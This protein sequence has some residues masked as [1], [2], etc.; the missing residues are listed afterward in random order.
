MFKYHQLQ[1]KQTNQIKTKYIALGLAIFFLAAC[2]SSPKEKDIYAVTY[3]PPEKI[4]L[5]AASSQERYAIHIELAQKYITLKQFTSANKLLDDILK[6]TSED[7]Y[8]MHL[9]AITLMGLQKYSE[10]DSFFKRSIAK[11]ANA[12]ILNNYG[13]LLCKQKNTQ[14]LNYLNQAEPKAGAILYPKILS[15]KGICY[16]YQKEYTQAITYLKK[17]LDL[18]PEYIPSKIY[19]AYIYAKQ[20]NTVGAEFMLNDIGLDRVNE[21]EL[22]WLGINVFKMSGNSISA[23]L[24]GNALVNEFPDSQEVLKFDR[25][26]LEE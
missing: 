24:W 7:A 12:D 5:K 9:K 3:D 4:A 8:A 19:L 16:L 11:D 22:L 15:T 13:W 6:D 1:N 2:S 10:S 26:I 20:N 23:K 17:S 14:G 21:P 18:N 25:N